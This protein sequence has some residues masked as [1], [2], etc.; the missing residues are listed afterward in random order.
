M[1]TYI[2]FGASGSIGSATTELLLNNKDTVILVSHNDE[3]LS[4]L[5]T[6]SNSLCIKADVTKQDE[7][8]SVFTQ[9]VEKYGSIDGVLHA[10]GSIILKPAHLTTA[11]EWDATMLINLTSAFYVVQ[12]SAKHMNA[13]SVVLFSSAAARIGLA[14]HEAI[15][16]AKAGVIG[17][18]R[19]AAASYASRGLRFNCIAPGLVR[20]ELSRKITSNPAAEKASLAF[21]PLGR[22]GEGSDIAPIAAWLLSSQS[23]WTTGEVFGLDGGLSSLK[24][25]SV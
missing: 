21:H 8:E 3:R 19:S 7:V 5:R 16:A 10:V 24:T 13:G 20:S 1:S 2:I 12:S 4:L 22:L 23:S 6:K 25:K 11:A 18:T 17:L 14:S 15:A 9:T